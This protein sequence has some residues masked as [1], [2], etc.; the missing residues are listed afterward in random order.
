M[1]SPSDSALLSAIPAPLLAWYNQVKR[2]L[3][4]RNGNDAYQVWISEIMLQQT[5][6]SA[7]LDYYARFMAALPNIAALA[8]VTEDELMKLWQG[9]GY[10]SRARNLQKTSKILQASY[11]C[12]FPE[13]YDS[14]RAL[15]GI[16]EYTA[17]AIASIA[18]R[19]PVPAVDGNVL[20]VL[21]R[22]LANESDIAKASTKSAFRDA[23]LAVIPQDTPG[24]FNQAIME[25]GETVCL[26]NG[27]P[28][29][30]KCPLKH[31]CNAHASG[32]AEE[33]PVKTKAKE[34]RIEKRNVYLFFYNGC[35]A[36]RRRPDTGLL[37]RLWEFP[38]E[39][40]SEID[41][42][43]RWGI[44]TS[45]IK[46]SVATGKHIFSHIEWH[47]EAFSLEATDPA[48]PEGW[49]WATSDELDSI[50][51]IPNAFRFVEKVLPFNY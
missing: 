7:V 28:L 34:R 40:T 14:I 18:F 5:R 35:V 29:C 16:G 51:A 48:L 32:R 20:R 46:R 45:G 12:R 44:H 9:L 36:L 21:T 6:I 38:N 11:C 33:L 47:M 24:E 25:L 10:Y 17:G 2:P 31:L 8:D 19:I 26:P 3:P 13:D 37:A 23:L 27:A 50:Y 1:F 49:V 42:L 22:I 41:F 43:L 30:G 39:D 15:P 4:W